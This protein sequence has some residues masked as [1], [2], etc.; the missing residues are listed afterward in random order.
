MIT[1]TE[2]TEL[3]RKCD[4]LARHNFPVTASTLK[5]WGNCLLRRKKG[6]PEAHVGPHW[7]AEVLKRHGCES[8]WSS[9][10]SH[11]RT[12]VN[13]PIGATIINNFFDE[14]CYLN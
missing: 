1:D 14:V 3:I 6:D 2:E 8:K 4:N 11:S 9:R 13:G 12:L 5:A 10:I 7:T